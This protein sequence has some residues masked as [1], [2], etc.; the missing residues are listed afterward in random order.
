MTRIYSSTG[1][2]LA[3]LMAVSQ[4]VNAV[5]A[6]T[7]PVGFAIYMGLPLIESA[8][9]GFVHVYGL[10]ALFIAVLVCVFLLLRDLRA[11]QWTAIAALV[12]PLGDVWLTI[13]ANAAPS[14]IV[15]HAVIA[16]VVAATA[17]LIFRWRRLVGDRA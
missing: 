11:L 6:L 5:R 12:M 1:F 9:V 14:I 3:V 2:W 15:R 4:S 7:D 17:V 8:D 10:R 13:Q 16:A